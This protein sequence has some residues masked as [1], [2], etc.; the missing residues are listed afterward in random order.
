MS[1]RFYTYD[2]RPELEQRKRPLLEAWPAFMFE[3]PVAGARW[4]LLYS[5]SAASSTSSSTKSRTS[6]SQR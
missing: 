2:E 6:W 4:H 5:A 3:D 1:L